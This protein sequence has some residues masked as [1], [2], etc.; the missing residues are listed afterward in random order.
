MRSLARELP[1]HFSRDCRPLPAKEFLKL[2]KTAYTPKRALKATSGQETKIEALQKAYV[3]LARSLAD[4]RP[5]ASAEQ[6]RR[7]F[8]EIGMRSSVIN[9]PNRV[10]GDAVVSLSERLVRE[11]KGLS[12]SEFQQVVVELI[13]LQN[14]TPQKRQ[15]KGEPKALSSRAKALL[16]TLQEIIWEYREGL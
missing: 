2:M 16:K 6:I 9:A 15:K 13:S 8:L 4:L 11:K 7:I 3:S 14:F 5:G 1:R 12:R 10:T